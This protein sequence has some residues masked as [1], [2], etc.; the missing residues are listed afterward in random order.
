MKIILKEKKGIGKTRQRVFL[1]LIFWFYYQNINPITVF[2]IEI[3][4]F[5]QLF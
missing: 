3:N 4:S 1:V 5:N 2:C